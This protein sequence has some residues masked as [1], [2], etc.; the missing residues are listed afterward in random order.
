LESMGEG[1]N[2]TWADDLENAFKKSVS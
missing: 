1:A 2:Y